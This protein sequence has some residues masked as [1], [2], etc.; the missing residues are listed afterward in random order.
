MPGPPASEEIHQLEALAQAIEDLQR[1]VAA[2]EGSSASFVEKPVARTLQEP[3]PAP[4]SGGSLA[5]LGRLLLAIAGAYLLRAFSEAGVLPTLAGTILGVL[6]ALG[7]LA[8]ALRVASSNRLTAAIHSVAAAAIAAPLLWEATARFHTL[9]AW[10]AALVLAL[11]GALG[12]S[13]AWRRNESGIAAIT[14]LGTCATAI[15]LMAAS[16]N[17]FPF[18]AAVV[19]SAAVVEGFALGDHALSWR[20]ISA[21]SADAC[22]GILIFVLTRP[23]GLPEGYGAVP[24]AAVLALLAAIAVIYVK[25]TAI[26]TAFGNR[27]IASFEAIQIVMAL[28]LCAIAVMVIAPAAVPI[29]G[30]AIAALGALCYFAA[31]FRR[32]IAR[33]FHAYATAALIFTL[34]GTSLLLPPP[35]LAVTWS[36]LAIPALAFARSNTVALHGVIFLVSAAARSGL[37]ASSA[38]ALLHLPTL[39]LNPAALLCV[40]VVALCYPLALRLRG[41]PAPPLIAASL[42][43]LVFTGLAARVLPATPVTAVICLVALTLAWFGTRRRELVWLLYAWMIAGAAKILWVDFREGSPAALAASFLLFGGALIALQRLL[44]RTNASARG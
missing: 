38:F 18:A 22:G 9:P 29:F 39:P 17:P 34:A 13:V 14:A 41:N 40:I 30:A 32:P 27:P 21:L 11:F 8:A 7:W 42:L 24:K 36:A 6:Y 1:R 16:L 35:I 4:F 44:K 15:C 23:D 33:N 31:L 28:S 12:Q 2:L 3:E 25:V 26:R 10:A 37:L 19:A 5:A 43:I 20:W